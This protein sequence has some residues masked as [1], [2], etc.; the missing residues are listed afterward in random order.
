MKKMNGG[1]RREIHR[2]L[3]SAAVLAPLVIV[4]A[5]WLTC[6]RS[7]AVVSSAV[8]FK[9]AS[10]V[11]RISPQAIAAWSHLLG[12]SVVV[13]LAALSLVLLAVCALSDPGYVPGEHHWLA[14]FGRGPKKPNEKLRLIAENEDSSNLD[15]WMELPS[16]DRAD[17]HSGDTIEYPTLSLTTL[18]PDSS[19]AHFDETDPEPEPEPDSIGSA[20]TLPTSR[21][22]LSLAANESGKL[23]DAL[24]MKEGATQ[25]VAPGVAAGG[26]GDEERVGEEGDEKRRGKLVRG[27]RLSPSA[28]DG[29]R[30]GRGRRLE[31]RRESST[32]DSGDRDED[33]SST[34]WM[35][36]YA[37]RKCDL[38]IPLKHINEYACNTLLEKEIIGKNGRGEL[39][40]FKWC[41]ACLHLKHPRTRHCSVCDRCCDK[42]DHHCIWC[43]MPSTPHPHTQLCTLHH[44]QHI[45][46][47]SSLTQVHSHNF[48]S[49][50]SAGF[51]IA[52]VCEIKD[53]FFSSF[54]SYLS[55]RRWL[56]SWTHS[57]FT[58]LSAT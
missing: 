6:T 8:G 58:L 40:R 22:P 24:D 46:H 17:N 41:P 15:Y 2:G 11:G 33:E 21:G 50:F 48:V 38:E 47:T 4:S 42:F 25:G 52:W 53:T 1:L 34:E 26:R 57:H 13:F 55:T 35:E 51:V 23:K 36:A 9:V 28:G 37:G 16:S 10:I 3:I 14:Y 39:V 20:A 56:P 54:T 19:E 18:P 49:V 45:I 30:R 32:S 27:G 5:A 7:L 12:S 44:I 43:V 31:E 29:R